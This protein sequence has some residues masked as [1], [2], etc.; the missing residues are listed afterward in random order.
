MTTCKPRAATCTQISRCKSREAVKETVMVWL[1]WTESLWLVQV[2]LSF[3]QALYIHVKFVGFCAEISRTFISL[4]SKHLST[5]LFQGALRHSQHV[6]YPLKRPGPWLFT[7]GRFH[8]ILYTRLFLF[9]RFPPQKN[10]W[11][12]QKFSKASCT[13]NRILSHCR[14]HIRPKRLR[15]HFLVDAQAYL[16]AHLPKVGGHC[17]ANLLQAIA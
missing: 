4:G 16:F 9:Q 6:S 15:Q 1:D 14:I 7:S 8:S 2:P 13:C 10:L 3:A 17:L 5:H 11:K 12:S